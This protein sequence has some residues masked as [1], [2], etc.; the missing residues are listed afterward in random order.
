MLYKMPSYNDGLYDIFGKLYET[1][2]AT[3]E[4]FRARAYKKAQETILMNDGDITRDNY[5]DLMGKPGIGDTIM[6][7]IKEY[8]DTGKLNILEREKDN[9]VLIFTKIYGVG[10]KKAQE[11]VNKYKFNTIQDLREAIYGID[12]KGQITNTVGLSILRHDILNDK[13]IIGLRYYEDILERIP[14]D[15][16]DKYNNQFNDIIKSI[17]QEEQFIMGDIGDT[18]DII[19]NIEIVGSYRRGAITSGDIDVIISNNRD[20]MDIFKRFVDVCLERNIVIEVLSRGKT[21]SLVIAKLPGLNISESHGEGHGEGDSEGHSEGHSKVDGGYIPRRVDFL[22]TTREEYPFAKLYFTGS[23]LFNTVMR[24]HAVDM[25]YT[26]NEHG[27]YKLVSGVK[28]DKVDVIFH[29]EGDIFTFLGLKYVEPTERKNGNNIVLLSDDGRDDGNDIGHGDVKDIGD[30]GEKEVQDKGAVKSIK[31]LPKSLKKKSLRN[32]ILKPNTVKDIIDDDDFKKG[33]KDTQKPKKRTIKIPRKKRNIKIIAHI[34]KDIDDDLKDIIDEVEIET[35]LKTQ[36]KLQVKDGIIDIKQ[37]VMKLKKGLK[38]GL[39]S[40]REKISKDNGITETHVSPTEIPKLGVEIGTSVGVETDPKHTST[41]DVKHTISRGYLKNQLKVF[42][43]TGIDF[44]HTK[45][46]K[47]LARLLLLSNELYY[48][49][50]PILSDSQYDILKEYIESEYPS[51][52]ALLLIGAPIDKQKD[53]V[54]L[55]YFMGSMDKIKPNTGALKS[56]KSKYKGPYVISTKL[57]GVSGLYIVKNGEK[58]LYTRG[59]G[60]Y[61]QDVSHLIPHLKLPSSLLNVNVGK[62]DV[63]NTFAI[64]GEFVMKK[65]VFKTKYE[66]KWS[67]P[68]NLV[69]G[70]VNSKT[71][72]VE[73]LDKYGDIDFVCYEIIEPTLSSIQQF[74]L[75]KRVSIEDKSGLIVSKYLVI[76]LDILKKQDLTNEFLSSL[77]IDWRTNYEYEID[78]III[79]NDGIYS[80]KDGNPEHSIAF[81]MVLSEQIVEAKVIDV[82]WTA[83]KDGYLKPRIRIEPVTIGGVIIEYATA[84]N[85]A[86]VRDKKIGIGTIIQLVRSGDVI[87]HIM[88]VIEPSKEPK[89]PTVEYKWNDTGVDILLI[90]KS[91]DPVVLLKTITGFFVKLGVIGLSIGN[92]KKLIDAGYDTV[93][94]IIKMEIGDFLGIDGFKLKMSTKIYDS[95]HKQIDDADISTVMSATNIFGRGLGEKRIVSILKKYPDIL[96]SKEGDLL[97]TEKISNIP[98]F[99]IK[100]ASNFVSHI[101]EFMKFMRDSGLDKMKLNKVGVV[102]IGIGVGDGESGSDGVDTSHELYDKKIVITGFRS[103]ELENKIKGF[104]GIIGSSVNK[105]THMV[106]VKDGGIGMDMDMENLT[107]S[108]AIKAKELGIRI[109]SREEFDDKFQ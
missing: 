95:I 69:S 92:V 93:I 5:G 105:T 63:K 61:G 10:P 81:K 55:P 97:K 12:I 64:R 49:D 83:S 75:M 51:E 7:K 16:I 11:L 41:K 85:G 34:K 14:R 17:C 43:Q 104:G 22:F 66:A 67:N 86:F 47:E 8:I 38:K 9:P 76:T 42:S 53:K 87:P 73:T 39:K 37:G 6:K 107:S 25:G 74:E 99:A 100:T 36:D 59:N 19:C 60:V 98:G 71:Q 80:R 46:Q 31:R 108:K 28:K 20:D 91:K 90:D 103:K 32:F 68:R 84:F 94:K 13:Q 3:G 50:E 77:L 58:K 35:L 33:V 30:I 96:V 52:K 4:P 65:E 70:I 56:W 21:K 54:K 79:S 15:E 29:D 1:M 89:M 78:G 18:G 72:D 2:M 48:N 109:I 82:I 40:K 24:K 57:D 102:C 101:P 88:D 26:M 62:D 45:T 27:I 106:I 44:L 23:A